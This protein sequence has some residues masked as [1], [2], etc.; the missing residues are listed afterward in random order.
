MYPSL[1]IPHV[2]AILPTRPFLFF[3]PLKLCSSLFDGEGRDPRYLRGVDPVLISEIKSPL[4][5]IFLLTSSNPEFPDLQILTLSIIV[6]V[7]P[8][9]SLFCCV[10]FVC[11]QGR[12]SGKGILAGNE[13]QG[14]SQTPPPLPE[15]EGGSKIPPPTPPFP[16]SLSPI[17]LGGGGVPPLA[18][19]PLQPTDPITTRLE[20]PTRPAPV[21]PLPFSRSL[22]L[23][24]AVRLR[25]PLP[26]V[27]PFVVSRLFF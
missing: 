27:A 12:L 7:G 17:S 11:A 1:I 6:S 18:N 14:V 13:G 10:V 22:S 24:A 23:L 21:P 8:G 4:I 9:F 25:H 20:N 3:P 26:V 15:G 19:R 16:N 5:V 2:R